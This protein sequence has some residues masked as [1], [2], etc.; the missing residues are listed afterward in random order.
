MK[1]LFFFA[2][3]FIFQHARSERGC[4]PR[5]ASKVTLATRALGFCLSRSVPG[6]NR[7][8]RS[9]LT[10]LGKR[11][12]SSFSRIRYR[13]KKK[14][15]L[16]NSKIQCNP[17]KRKMNIENSF[18]NSLT[19]CNERVRIGKYYTMYTNIDLFKVFRYSF[20]RSYRY[21]SIVLKVVNQFE[22]NG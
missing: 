11:L 3:A 10:Q 18:P 7:K 14:C 12:A 5:A 6:L 4:R 13:N 8:T 17:I 22:F 1:T 19:W 20:Q 2:E 21:F 15:G 16:E 9:K